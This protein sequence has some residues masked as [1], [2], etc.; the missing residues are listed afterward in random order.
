MP[1]P[2]LVL[3]TLL[4]GCT[5]MAT[6]ASLPDPSALTFTGTYRPG[7]PCNA[8]VTADGKAILLPAG[9]RL[10][11]IPDGGRVTVMGERMEH[12]ARC[13]G[14]ALVLRGY[15]VPEN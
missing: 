5:P 12:N 13:G 4:A 1:R 14:P 2:A 3:A 11:G 8:V 9:V 10:V 7:T 6:S 15:F